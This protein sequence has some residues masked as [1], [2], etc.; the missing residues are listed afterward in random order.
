MRTW[1]VYSVFVALL[2]LLKV[3]AAVAA[4][5]ASGEEKRILII[6]SYGKPTA[7]SEI[8]TDKLEKEI[9]ATHP[10]WMVFSGNLKTESAVYTPAASLTLRSI[11]WGYAERTHTSVD[12]TDMKV[13][14]LFMQDD[15]PDAIAWIGEEGFMHY[16]S[17]RLL[18]GKWREIPMVLCAVG[19]SV[20]A[21][22][23]Y[24]EHKFNFDSMMGIRDY[25]VINEPF[26]T[27]KVILDAV[28]NDKNIRTSKV[29]QD[30]VEGYE[31]ELNM[32]YSGNIVEFPIRQN[33]ELIHRLLPDLKELVWVDDDSYRCMKA[34]LELERIFS[35]TM[36]GV[37]YVKM[38]RNYMN[39]DSIYDVM[40][41]PAAHRAFLTYTLNIDGLHGKRSDKEMDSLFTHVSTVPLFT[42]TERDFS[43]NNYWI[44]GRFLNS[45]KIANL[46]LAKLERAVQENNI[47]TIPFDTLS[48]SEIVL[49]R[50]ALERYGLTRMADELKDASF[51]H[52]PPSFYRKYEKYL[53]VAGLILV[54][55]ACYVFISLRQS[56]YNR[57]IKADYA[58][59]KRLYDKSQVIYENSSIDFALYDEHGKRLLR[60]VSGKVGEADKSSDLF[61]EDIFDS[62][63]LSDE[64]K[65]QIRSKRAVNC[66]VS[67]DSNGQLS[68]TSFIENNIYQLIVKPLHEVSN[69]SSC[70]MAIAIN[71]TPTIRERREKERF[72]GLFR[73]A[74]DS[75]Q[76]GVVFYDINTV[77][78]M[79]T[80]SWCNNMNETFVSGTLP[81]YK[82]VVG[83]DR[84]LLLEYQ[85]TLCGGTV[86]DPLCRDIQVNGKDGE[87]HWIRQHMYYI[88]SSNRLVE[89]SLD[90]DEQKQNEKWLEDAKQ[91]AEESNEESGNFLSSIS[92]EVRTPLNSIVGFSAIMAVLDAEEAG[93]EYVPIILRNIRLLDALI[94]NILDLSA[95]DGGKISFQYTNVQIDEVFVEMG[96]FI[97][98][99]LYHQSLQVINELP[100]NEADRVII[101]DGKYLRRLLLSLL[102]N[103]VKFT[104]SGSVMLG[105]RKQ[106]DGFY[107]YI[108]DTGCGITDED[109][110]HIFNRFTKLD[111]YMQG[112]G[113]GLALCKSIVKHLGGEIGVISEKGKGSTFWFVLPDNR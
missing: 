104:D 29:F 18:L 66:E 85:Q 19:D 105:C 63:S 43:E 44:G 31:I 22:G 61:F 87:I 73:F 80:D 2:L 76:V 97:R 46:S 37:K 49:N 65:E 88:Q 35:E 71:L 62:P 84:E 30:G 23:W 16:L 24:P 7:W 77:V 5:P 74:S 113:L 112:T 33:L 54:M 14:T 60:I 99:N 38:I 110:K 26:T 41:Q 94:A 57:R 20:L 45:S 68:R 93:D 21:E 90:I 75:S 40:L 108:T 107:F 91:K 102:S 81:L 32:N 12:A 72:E 69:V 28:K 79:A 58:R 4:V 55:V 34:R 82:Q 1:I 17:Y 47:M 95:L 27:N 89:L 52:I 67:L 6:N 101:T 48:E 53:L 3:A 98:N 50:T 64:L 86:L 83:K 78:G 103:A 42:L 100:E 10:D 25:A 36:P 13:T 39:T 111:S 11:L 106:I 8:V 96:A 70:F 9:H 56:R 109:Q 51:V 15:L 92:H 59:Y